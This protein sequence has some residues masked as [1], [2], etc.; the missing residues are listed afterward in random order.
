MSKIL[1]IDDEQSIRD[2]LSAS[3]KDE[4][5]E[6]L[7]AANGDEGLGLI[8]TFG[9]DVV[10]LD[11]WMPGHRDGL[12]ILHE[13]RQL[14]PDIE[15]VMISGHGTIETA[16]KATK[17]GAYDFIE[18]PLS[19]DKISITIV[20]AIN[21]RQSQAEKSALLNK[22]RSNIA[23]R[24]DSQKMMQTKQLI[25][26]LAPT[27]SWIFIT[28]ESG[29]GKQLAAQN[30]H[31]MSPRASRTFAEINCEMI[32]EDLIEG[33]IFGIEKGAL[34]GVERSRKGKLELV[35][36]GTLYIEE[37]TSMPVHLQNKLLRFMQERQFTRFMGQ[38]V[39][40]SEARIIVS[41]SESPEKAIQTGTLRQDFFDR[42]STFRLH[43]EPLRNRMED[44]TS[45]IT[46]FA[47]IIARDTGENK[48]LFS[49]G[50]VA[51]MKSH[52]WAG[53]IREL[54]NFIERVYILTPGDFVDIHDLR[55]AGL[56]ESGGGTESKITEM[57]TFREARA[58]FEKE[59]LEKKIQ[60]NGGNI[61]K[62]AEVIGLERS[63]LHRKIKAYGIEVNG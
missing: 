21:Y 2:I 23:I 32:P 1:I 52:S 39:V 56:V 20:N 47:D 8:K 44:L 29:T 5:Y 36:N 60:E 38:E 6:V 27:Q 12:E 62:T 30:I 59:Y 61:S 26:K 46:H 49:D 14:F 53:N 18:K 45:L 41:S 57:Q 4:G 28:G 37:I 16:V 55:F 7:T 51:L 40:K 58:G 63:Y 17:L 10:F 13:A 43:L 22:L 35:E 54:K 34:T 25:A 24:G 48:K 50:A 42:L 9:P 19:I 11:I 15:F 33:E 31:Y 3:L